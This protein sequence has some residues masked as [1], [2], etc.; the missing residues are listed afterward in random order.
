MLS[1]IELQDLRVFLTLADQLHYGRTAEFLGVTTSNVSY[2]IRTLE[3]RLGGRLFHRTSRRV[4]LSPLGEELQARITENYETLIRAVAQ[5]RELAAGV[6]GSIRIGFTAKTDGSE[7][8]HLTQA[9]QRRY[10]QCQL[11]LQEIENQDPYRLLR[12]GLIDVLVNW[13]AVDEPDLTAGPA[14]GHRERVLAVA[15]DH[16]LARAER[17][18]LEDLAEEQVCKP[19]PSYPVALARAISPTHTPTGRAIPRVAA[20]RSSNEIVTDVARGRM[21]HLTVVGVG[22]Y[23]RDDITLIPI[24]DMAPLPLGPIWVTK[25][26]NAKIRAFAQTAGL[27]SPAHRGTTP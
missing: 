21:V 11:E 24:T 13:L 8:N 10:E 12:R 19:P 4:A 25:N 22:M 1:T 9:F 7:L 20:L 5:T 17:V 16:R 14:I 26:E 27:L 18:S 2:T 15:R 23:Q 3:T 6:V